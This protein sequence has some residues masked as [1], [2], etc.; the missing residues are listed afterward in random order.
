MITFT[1]VGP[2]TIRCTGGAKPVLVFPE[3]PVEGSICLMPAP[4]E[5]PSR[6][7]I[8]WPGEYDV[9]GIT[10]RGI[11]HLEGQKVSYAIAI[12]DTRC[13]FPAS[14]LEEWHS[15]DIERLGD[16]HV[17]ALPAADPK[18]FQMLLDE[19]DPRLLIII[20]AADGSLHPEVLK[21]AGAAD[22][23]PVSEYKLKGALP[24]EGREVVVLK[25]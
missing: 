23:E 1:A 6:D 12:D 2:T 17:L 9:A 16:I 21:A 15:T 19:I 3:K 14:P 20:P 13:A 8:S 25:A 18:K 24:A 11:G 22:K 7:V 4:E 10:I 5:N